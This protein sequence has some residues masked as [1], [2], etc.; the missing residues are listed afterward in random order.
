MYRVFSTSTREALFD[1]TDLPSRIPSVI[2][3]CGMF[4]SFQDATRYRRGE[5]G[6]PGGNG[7]D[8]GWGTHGGNG[9]TG[10]R[11]NIRI[12]DVDS[13]YLMAF[14]CCDAVAAK[15][16][17]RGGRPGRMGSHGAPGRPGA[18]GSGGRSKRWTTTS[19]SGDNQSTHHHHMPGGF[20]GPRGRSGKIIMHPLS[21][22]STG[23]NGSLSIIVVDGPSR[24]YGHRYDLRLGSLSITS[25]H[26]LRI[27]QNV[28][29]FTDAV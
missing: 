13:Y 5:D 25:P 14:P 20:D 15:W 11:I 22:G 29:Q 24:Q 19:G 10:G 9:G 6:G 18:G 4:Y 1:S 28:F 16:A 12:S 17:V 26:R 8:A 23:G 3:L 2:P 7:G 21:E 27:R